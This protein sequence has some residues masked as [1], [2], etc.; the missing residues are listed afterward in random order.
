MQL[1]KEDQICQA[2]AAAT[3]GDSSLVLPARNSVKEWGRV[4]GLLGTPKA[5]TKNL[6]KERSLS[7]ISTQLVK[8][9]ARVRGASRA[10]L[11]RSIKISVKTGATNNFSHQSTQAELADLY[12]VGE[13][14]L[15]NL[16]G[17]Y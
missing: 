9:L 3:P 16:W 8:A 14:V 17:I 6:K 11:R 5:G 1:C 4:Q 7:L 2:A 13:G 10:P 15:N 12:I